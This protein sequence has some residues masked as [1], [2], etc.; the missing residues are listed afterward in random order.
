MA[1]V[2][3]ACA[4]LCRRLEPHLTKKDSGFATWQ[5]TVKEVQD[6]SAFGPSSVMLSAYGFYDGTERDVNGQTTKG[7]IHTWCTCCCSWQRAG[8]RFSDMSDILNLISACL[9]YCCF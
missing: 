8:L 5:A 6:G 9:A 7:D 3:Q 2:Q 4:K 1:A